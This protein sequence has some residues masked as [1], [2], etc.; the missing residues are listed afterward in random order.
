MDACA[1]TRAA[2]A[3]RCPTARSAS[4]R[5]A[6]TKADACACR[7]ATSAACSAIRSRRSRSSTPIPGALAYSFGMLGCDL[8]C[9]YCQNW[10]T[11]QALR[12]PAAVAPPLDAT[13]EA[14]VRDALRLG[15]ARHRQH[16]QR[17]A[18][19][20]RVGGRGVQGSEGRRTRHRLRVERQR[21][22]ARCSSTCGRGSISTRSISRA[23]TT[24]TIASSADASQPILDTIRRLHA[25]GFWVEI[26]TLLIPGFNDSRRRA[27]APDG[28]RRE[29]VARHPVARHG[30][31][32]R[33]QDDRAAEHDGRHAAARGGDRRARPACAT[34]TPATCPARSATSKTPAAPRCR[35]TLVARRG[36]QHPRLPRHARR[37]LPGVRRAGA[38]T[39]ER[40][41]DGQIASRPFSLDSRSACRSPSVIIERCA[42]ST[43]SAVRCATSACRSPTAATCA[44]STA[45]RRRSTSG[46]RART[47]CTSRRSRALVDV[48]LG[49]R[50]RSAA[51]DRRR[52]AAAPRSA[53][54]WSRCSPRKP[55]LADLALTTN[56]VLLA[57]QV[58][59]L[60]AAGLRRI[61]VSLD[62]LR[63][64]SLQ[65]A[66]ALRRA[67][68]RARRHGRG[69]ARVRPRLQD[70]HRRHQGRQRR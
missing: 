20:E 64:R 6:S 36:Y 14:L 49:R 10:V 13:P 52:T 56:G 12:D 32:R 9:G 45:C 30:V 8:H 34:S 24:A 39:L 58:D 65:G 2:T 33:L 38:R 1:A 59:A 43:S 66:H 53:R 21:H 63:R 47:C 50:R 27:D 35:E 46:C 61:T 51:P 26:V 48:F 41:F 11:S 22:A 19:H 25:M 15:R 42:R 62:T 5:C 70:R 4:A 3:A 17:A 23:S 28:V 7:G 69:A 54:R 29:R 18:D 67:R 55:G 16:L 40:A 60:A 31:S 57:E 44:A 37:P 68:A